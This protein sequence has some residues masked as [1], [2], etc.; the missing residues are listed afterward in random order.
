LINGEKVNQ[1]RV[2]SGER[3][4]AADIAPAG[5]VC[6]VTGL[7]RSYPGQGLGAE[8]FAP[9]PEL[10]PILSY[11]VILPEGFDAN[12]ALKMFRELEDEDPLLAVHWREQT[13]ELRLS[14][15]GEVQL[16]VTGHTV[17]ERFGLDV[18]FDEG[19][20]LYRE[21]IAEPVVGIGHFEP[22]RHYAEVHLL[23]EPG[24][25]GSGL[26]FDTACSEDELAKS[27]QRLILTHLAEREH[28]GV[29]TGSPVTDIK[30]TLLAGRAHNKHTEGGD[31]RQATYRAVRQGLM[32][33][34][35]ILLEPQYRFELEVPAH[36]AGRAMAD[37]Q[38]RTDD[39]TPPAILGESAVLSG[40]APVSAMRGYAAEIAASTRGMGRLSCVSAGFAPCRNQ[41]EMIAQTGYE[42]LRDTE[43]PA[44]SVF[45]SHGAGFIV[46]WNEVQARAH[47]DSGY[48]PKKEEPVTKPSASAGKQKD[49]FELDQELQAIY[50]QTYGAVRRRDILPRAKPNRETAETVRYTAKKQPEGPE[51]LLVDGYN[52]IHA[53]DELRK[54]A[55]DNLDA[56]RQV[57]LDV[58]S[59]YG[60]FKGRE[61]IVVFDA[62]KVPGGTGSVNKYHNIHVVYTKEAETADAYIEKTTAALG[63]KHRV[64]VATSDAAVQMI[65]F[66]QGALRFTPQGL[67]EEIERASE[68]IRAWKV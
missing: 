21:T 10:A 35:S 61:I 4:T 43:N 51:Y 11:R 13:G 64:A 9:P 37:L 58:M 12:R 45:C 24:P 16:E 59:N 20:V 29:L 14:L 31:F 52:I 39:V 48:R 18:G 27:W 15:M 23:L 56:A 54:L 47:V 19:S 36:C 63:K 7:A 26:V 44:D 57:L 50:E 1:V 42:A 22:L 34:Q 41:A 28:P 8:D 33:A 55:A 17:K 30:I 5:T 6:A 38:L 68:E 60:A 2:Y 40:S 46:P 25:R 3:F 66:G 32:Q 67:R 49:I 62:Y 53:W 65:I